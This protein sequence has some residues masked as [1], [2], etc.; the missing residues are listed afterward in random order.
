MGGATF[1]G[2][3]YQTERNTLP[4]ERSENRIIRENST[5]LYT[6]LFLKLSIIISRFSYKACFLKYGSTVLLRAQ[7]INK[8][9][10]IRSHWSEA[11]TQLLGRTVLYCTL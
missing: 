10:E 1:K 8:Q 3:N 5:V 7:I 11:K 6:I 4:L 9:S 2:P